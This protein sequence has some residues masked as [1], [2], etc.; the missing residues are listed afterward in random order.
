MEDP[1][2]IQHEQDVVKGAGGEIDQR[3]FHLTLK[4]CLKTVLLYLVS[5]WFLIGL[6]VLITLAWRWPEFGKD[7]GSE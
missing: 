6:G 2:Y 4:H 7:G 1:K 3:R 5:Q